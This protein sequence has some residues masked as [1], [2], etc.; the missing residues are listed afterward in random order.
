MNKHIYR[1]ISSPTHQKKKKKR[2]GKSM[3]TERAIARACGKK[4]MGSDCWWSCGCFGGWKKCSALRQQWWL[5]D[6][7]SVLKITGMHLTL[8]PLVLYLF[9][10]VNSMACEL[11]LNQKGISD[12][13]FSTATLDIRWQWDIIL[14][15]WRKITRT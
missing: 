1:I 11:Y 2:I 8:K 3:D 12:S 4:V 10:R 5:R 15:H 6:L 9:E 14:K 7:V 13:A